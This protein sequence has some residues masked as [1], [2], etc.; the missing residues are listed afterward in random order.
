MN[1][2]RDFLKEH[3]IYTSAREKKLLRFFEETF[4]EKNQMIVQLKGEVKQQLSRIEALEEA[5]H[6][7]PARTEGVMSSASYK[8]VKLHN[9]TRAELIEALE[10]TF[11]HV[12]QLHKEKIEMHKFYDTIM[13]G[14][15]DRLR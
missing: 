15:D 11:D 8:G 13:G 5:L 10:F 2:I 7:K 4:Q 12:R 14:E 6:G 3:D 9:L 1:Y